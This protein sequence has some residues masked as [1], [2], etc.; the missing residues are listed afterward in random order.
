MTMASSP[1]YLL[2]KV[3]MHRGDD[4]VSFS[5]FYCIVSHVY[6]IVIL[7]YFV[8]I[9]LFFYAIPILILGCIVVS[10]SETQF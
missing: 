7:A 3:H 5:H 9:L 6:C 10:F 1:N 2:I 8:V 4:Y